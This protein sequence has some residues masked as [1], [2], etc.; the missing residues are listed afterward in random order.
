MVIAASDSPGARP[1]PRSTTAPCSPRGLGKLSSERT[2]ERRQ[3]WSAPTVVRP[4]NTANLVWRLGAP[5]ARRLIKRFDLRG[6]QPE[7]E[8]ARIVGRLLGILRPRNGNDTS[9]LEE[10]PQRNLSR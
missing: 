6:G 10:P 4:L 8:R 5:R 1:T 9:L 2:A 3:S 7:R